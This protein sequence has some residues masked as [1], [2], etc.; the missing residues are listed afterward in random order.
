MEVACCP[1]GVVFLIAKICDGQI[2]DEN[3]ML[4]R[5]HISSLI[6]DLLWVSVDPGY[7]HTSVGGVANAAVDFYK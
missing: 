2:C 6:S 5:T 4:I 1:T 7:R 3:F